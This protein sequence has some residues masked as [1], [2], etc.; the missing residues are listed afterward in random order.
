MRVVSQ[1]RCRVARGV[2]R[3]RRRRFAGDRGWHSEQINRYDVDIT[4]EPTGALLIRETIDYDF[5][6]VPAS[7]DLPR[8]PGARRLPAEGESRSR[9]PD[10]RDLGAGVARERRADY[11]VDSEG[12]NERIKIGDPDR[13]ITGE[14]QYEIT[15]RVRGAMN[16]FAD[17]DELVWNA[18]GGEWSVPIAAANVTVHA[19]AAITGVNCA[20]G[21]YGSNLAVRLGDRSGD[22]ATFTAKELFPG[23][24][25]G[26][27]QG[28]TVTVA[29]P[30]GAV[31]EPK[32]IL[33]ERFTLASAF[34]VTPATGGL[35]VGMLIFLVAVVLG[36]VWFFGRDRRYKGSAVDA[37]YGTDVPNAPEE[38]V[39]LL[40]EHE[41]PVEFVPPDGLRPGQVGTLVDFKANPLDVTA[42]IVDLAVR[43]Y[44]MIEELSEGGSP[45]LRRLE[46][47][48]DEGGR[49]RADALRAEA[50]RRALPRRS[51]GEALGS[52]VRVLGSH[53][54]GA[55]GA[56]GRR[57]AARVV[58]RACGLG[59][60]AFAALGFLVLRDRDRPHD[61]ARD[62]DPRRARRDTR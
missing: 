10:R 21:S 59:S 33:E 7:R 18:I 15:Y 5:G 39:P 54:R 17:H 53:D 40:G 56:A 48:S 47:H 37:A 42:T 12:D 29:I 3:S 49:R 41:T 60:C 46:A 52:A 34:R 26:P 36:L 1:Y 16:G 30:K 19:P 14:H 55:H 27:Y 11:S 24:A 23:Y 58:R 13:T 35:A 25:L 61:R 57:E 51:R 44:L 31:P 28:M 20:E 22:T 6:V 2:R 9:V 32:P 8:H 4:I 45:P 43:G 62:L 38:R 50:A